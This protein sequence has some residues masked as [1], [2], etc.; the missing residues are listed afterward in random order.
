MTREPFI[1]ARQAAR[2]VG[3]EPGE[4][5]ARTDPQMRAFYQWVSTNRVP[6]HQRGPRVLVFR[7]S[8]LE[9]V[10]TAAERAAPEASLT[11][12]EQLAREHILRVV[13]R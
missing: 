9:A 2:F 8:E 13:K 10:I 4:G 6:K 5:P 12:M 3:F 11:R 7:L 1:N